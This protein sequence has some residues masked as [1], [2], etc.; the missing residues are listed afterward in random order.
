MRPN[1]IRNAVCL[2][3]TLSIGVA[4][5]HATA[6]PI[7]PALAQATDLP[8]VQ[9]GT[10]H[11]EIG[12][13]NRLADVVAFA[14]D[15]IWAAGDG[16]AHFDGRS[17]RQT[18]EGIR[19]RFQAIAGLSATQLWAVGLVD[20]SAPNNPGL[21]ASSCHLV[22][23]IFRRQGDTWRIE[24]MP[25]HD[26][27]NDLILLS[28]TEG[29]AVGGHDRAVILRYDGQRW[30][31]VAAPEE[32]A[33]L[34]A[35]S[36]AGDGDLWAVGRQGSI[37]HLENGVWRAKEGP[38]F[39]DLSGIHMFSR[40][41]G[42]AVGYERDTGTGLA[43]SFRSG[44]WRLDMLGRTPALTAVH[45]LAPDL[46]FAVGQHGVL[47]HHDGRTWK[48]FGRSNPGDIKPRSQAGPSDEVECRPLLPPSSAHKPPSSDAPEGNRPAA[49]D[50]PWDPWEAENML[51][52]LAPLDREHV[53][54]V[55]DAGQV[56][57]ISD[58]LIW[59][60]L[61]A[62][63]E[64]VA[65]DMFDVGYGWVLTKGGA[66]MRYAEGAWNAPA[67]AAGGEWLTALDVV[68]RDDVWAV[69]RYGTVSHWSGRE[70][71]LYPQFTWLDFSA[72]A[73]A[74]A[75]H[76]WAVA[77][78]NADHRRVPE[79]HV[80]AWDGQ[81]WRQVIRLCDVTLT[82]IEASSPT[83]VWFAGGGGQRQ[84]LLHFDGHDWT[85]Q[86]IHG[87][88]VPA[89][90]A[91]TVTLLARS[92]GGRLWGGGYGLAWL[93]AGVW[94]SRLP[95]NSLYTQRLGGA[96]ETGVWILSRVYDSP[97]DD[98]IWSRFTSPILNYVDP[99]RAPVQLPPFSGSFN[100]MAAVVNEQGGTDVWLVGEGGTA[101]RY[102]TPS[103]EILLPDGSPTPAFPPVILAPSP[104]PYSAITRDQAMAFLRR[105]TEGDQTGTAEVQSL[106]LISIHEKAAMESAYRKASTGGG[107]WGLSSGTSGNSAVSLDPCE[108]AVNKAIWAAYL[109]ESRYCEHRQLVFF[110]LAGDG[111]FAYEL[112]CSPQREGT[113]LLPLLVQYIKPGEG[114]P[115]PTATRRLVQR[116]LTPQPAA[117]ATGAC[118]TRTPYPNPFPYPGP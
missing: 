82:D 34:L 87:N 52:A 69:G 18:I 47:V 74:D 102:R 108:G 38:D 107:G 6:L 12:G 106:Q 83:D 81:T 67:H 89:D 64:L 56:I 46:A 4:M 43:L 70:W 8:F 99:D 40:D 75:D 51:R 112:H 59:S 35:I 76:G 50:A 19:P 23:V 17:W 90:R 72:V 86:P 113:V 94:R 115:T 95:D 92:P 100:D 116:N 117:A 39:A 44:T 9:P 65:V 15:D 73:F 28:P 77:Q 31:P 85:W 5:G 109:A 118:P 45:I 14:G 53:V 78:D 13:F 48:E 33:G 101:L 105:F 37:V 26:R 66:P 3:L 7:A 96:T 20:P 55:G 98:D 114:A 54:A 16:I 49:G 104:T 63:R 1:P 110:D 11:A 21:A 57:Q 27:I 2:G 62:A 58:G 79:A 36:D 93:E 103:R 61:H 97:F 88:P 91:A 42:L 41:Y 25:L 24:P 22:S 60:E 30:N 29:W 68:A 32:S 10:W 80:F 111:S 71:N 84:A